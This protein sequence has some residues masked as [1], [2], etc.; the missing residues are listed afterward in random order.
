MSTYNLSIKIAAG[1]QGQ[2]AVT[3]LQQALAQLKTTGSSVKINDPTA[4]LAANANGATTA[5]GGL[6]AKF[7]GLAAAAA[8]AVGPIVAL[9]K[10][11]DVNSEIENAT[12]GIAS[13]VSAMTD[14]RDADGKMLTGSGALAGAIEISKE[15]MDK[16]RVAGIQT[17]A[18]FTQLVG[19]YQQ[20]IGAGSSA[21]LNLDEILKLTVNITQAAGALGVPM[22][23]LNQ[24]VRS[25]LSGQVTADSTVG[26]A[27]GLKNE[28]LKLWREQGVLAD[29]LNEKMAAF[30]I[31]G[32]A[33]AQTMT[34]M[35]SNMAD[36]VEL[37]LSTAT[38][39]AFDE[40]KKGLQDAL[41]GA[42]DISNGKVTISND[43]QG[44]ADFAKEVFDAVGKFM[45][46]AVRAGAN[47][48]KD[49]S[50]WLAEN[51]PGLDALV[52][53]LGALF[54]QISGIMRDLLTN[55]GAIGDSLGVWNDKGGLFADLMDG[56]AVMIATLRD[57]V[58]AILAGFKMMGA[59]IIENISM[60]LRMLR[61]AF[62]AL[63][64]AIGGDAVKGLDAM[65]GG[66]KN[67]SQGLLSDA[68][69]WAKTMADGGG[70]A[71][72]TVRNIR[73]RRENQAAKSE[74]YAESQ[75]ATEELGRLRDVHRQVE[76]EL[77]RS[78]DEKLITQADY[79]R[80]MGEL[81]MEEIAAENRRAEAKFALADSDA[82]KRR[83]RD[84]ITRREF[85]R[86]KIAAGDD[87]RYTSDPRLTKTAEELKAEQALLEQHAKNA[88][89]IEQQ[90]IENEIAALD[91]EYEQKLI[92]AE[93]YYKKLAELKTQAVDA[94]IKALN[95]S[96]SREQDPAKLEKLRG[97]IQVLELSKQK[98]KTEANAA[99]AKDTTKDKESWAKKSARELKDLEDAAK[100][101][102]RAVSTAQ[103]T[104]DGDP[105]KERGAKGYWFYK[106]QQQEVVDQASHPA[107]DAAPGAFK[108][109]A[110]EV[111]Q[112]GQEVATATAPVVQFGHTL[113]IALSQ[114]EDRL[115]TVIE[116]IGQLT[117]K[118]NEATTAALNAANA[119]GKVS[120]GSA[121]TAPSLPGFAGGGPVFGPGTG[122]SDSILASL[123]NG[124]FVIP[125]DAVRKWGVGHFEQYRKVAP[126]F[127]EG[128]LVGGVQSDIKQSL[129]SA[130]AASKP[131]MLTV[132][133]EI[134]NE[135]FTEW[136]SSGAADKVFRNQIGKNS[137]YIKQVV[138]GG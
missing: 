101:A 71:S 123:S 44:I 69:T 18:T 40:L 22:E 126:R 90:R 94:E 8:T 24:E 66:L 28:E 32:G 53:S 33:Q 82:Q 128:G 130:G 47:G 119:V 41:S 31:A 137:K 26:R 56:S 77:K 2:Q 59:A 104:F 19:A 113:G 61:E 115:P 117:I 106:D 52:G 6:V 97:E 138:S 70:N 76:E 110:N 30:A 80:R 68:K 133:N 7:A 3:A 23:Q 16:L 39:G 60:P 64:D 15:Q 25:I 92:S 21:G 51:K 91:A 83:L 87:G 131:I 96:A 27:L 99:L 81:R 67:T 100:S 136:A 107:K 57:G 86:D 10:G 120:L 121:G 49:I 5:L 13:L 124:E 85:E 1:V 108:T 74:A 45:A 98:I 65:L 55:V 63:P 79:N 9:K 50:A 84:E 78:L 4:G 54:E 11:L 58:E 109:A 75:S 116:E 118:L 125:A 34:A 42:F 112:L 93:A 127:A 88:L 36:A 20:A 129:A 105:M 111:Q 62:S 103:N 72:T 134:S 102:G 17:S 14:V 43:L 35:L 114:P 46:D 37:F 132:N 48:L 29:K 89:A 38:G 135:M 95:D 12:L 122:T 73:E